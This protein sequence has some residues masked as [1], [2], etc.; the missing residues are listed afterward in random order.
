MAIEPH[1]AR[2][3]DHGLGCVLRS[4][5]LV[6]PMVLDDWDHSEI[7]ADVYGVKLHLL[8]LFNF[9]P[10]S[11]AA[12]YALSGTGHVP[13]FA[14]QKLHLNVLRPLGS[15]V[16][17]CDYAWFDG[18]PRIWRLHAET[19]RS[20]PSR[21]ASPRNDATFFQRRSTTYVTYS[22]RHDTLGLCS[23]RSSI[24]RSVRAS[25][26]LRRCSDSRERRR[27]RCQAARVGFTFP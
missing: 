7:M 19:S 24:R 11:D 20:W 2:V 9:V 25:D 13:S 1:S 22:W 17:C 14:S 5:A 26:C 8:D 12:R 18:H 10:D 3:R 15:A 21:R 23:S 4:F 27:R 16:T 6:A